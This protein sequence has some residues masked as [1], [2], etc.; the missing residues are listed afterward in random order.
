MILDS[1]EKPRAVLLTVHL[2]FRCLLRPP[3]RVNLSRLPRLAFLW[4]VCLLF[5]FPLHF[6]F[7][8]RSYNCRFIP[9]IPKL[10][11]FLAGRRFF[12]LFPLAGELGLLAALLLVVVVEYDIRQRGM[13]FGNVLAANV[14][15]SVGYRVRKSR[16]VLMV[17]NNS[18]L[19]AAVSGQSSRCSTVSLSWFHRL[20]EGSIVRSISFLYAEKA[21]QFWLPRFDRA[22]QASKNH[23]LA[24]IPHGKNLG[25]KANAVTQFSSS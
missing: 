6:F 11:Q 8:C 20:H 18:C 9:S 1:N 2:F 3:P 12:V 13:L 5:F 17:P 10:V 7:R 14:N 25:S 24:S 15:V 21:M 4:S 16:S 19:V 23:Y 22:W